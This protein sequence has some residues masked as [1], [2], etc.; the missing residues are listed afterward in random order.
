MGLKKRVELAVLL[1]GALTA[2]AE[3][4]RIMIRHATQLRAFEAGGYLALLGALLVALAV[5]YGVR[6]PAER[7][8]AGPETR[9]V[10]VAMAVLVAYALALPWLG[11]L[12]STALALVVFLRIFG[13][14]R[15]PAVLVFAGGVSLLSAWLWSALAIVLPRGPLPWP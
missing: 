15:W 9:W 4:L 14:Y 11:Y 6:A 10:L 12:V 1:L 5:V 7:W 3:G 13:V 8:E 2:L